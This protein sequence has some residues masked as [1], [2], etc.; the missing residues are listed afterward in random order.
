VIAVANAI[1]IEVNCKIVKGCFVT[2]LEIIIR[3]RSKNTL[4]SLQFSCKECCNSW[5]IRKTNF[6]PIACCIISKYNS[7]I[8]FKKKE[9]NS[10][11]R[12]SLTFIHSFKP[13]FF[14]LFSSFYRNANSISLC[15]FLSIFMVS[16][17][18]LVVHQTFSI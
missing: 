2:S 5:K 1:D 16:L 7:N 18:C 4:T 17:R 9:R 10:Y 11:I 3:D 13:Y 12:T 6:L 15:R 14:S 8:F